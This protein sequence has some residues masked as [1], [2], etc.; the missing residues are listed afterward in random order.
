[1][2]YNGCKLQWDHE[3]VDVP[4]VTVEG[5]A[6]RYC[7]QNGLTVQ[8]EAREDGVKETYIVKD[9][10]ALDALALRLYGDF[11][12]AATKEN[13][14]TVA[15]S[16]TGERRF[17]IE[18]PEVW[19]ADG[20]PLRPDVHLENCITYSR[21]S[22]VFSKDELAR[23]AWPVTIDP[24]VRL[25]QRDGGLENTY[26][27][28]D[29]TT[30]YYGGSTRLVTGVYNTAESVSLFRLKTP[31][32][33]KASDT[34][35]SAKLMLTGSGSSYFSDNCVLGAYR[36]TKDWDSSNVTWSSFQPHASGS[37]DTKLLSFNTSNRNVQTW[38]ITD[39]YLSWYVKDEEGNVDNN[40]IALKRPPDITY[41]SYAEW[42]SS[43]SSTTSCRPCIVVDYLSHAGLEDWWQYETM[44]AGR[45]GTAH[46]DLLNG[47]LV[48]SHPDLA[49]GGLKLPFA[50]THYYNSCLSRNIAPHCGSGWRTSAHQT[51]RKDTI[52]GTDY[53]TWT[54]G[55]GTDH[56]FKATGS[57]PWEDAEG[58]KLRLSIDTSASTA[59][60][61]D[62]SHSQMVFPLPTGSGK[63]YIT[64][65]IDAKG[66]G[67]TNSSEHNC[68][69]T[70]TWDANAAGKL[71][72]A[73]DGAGR[74]T[75]FEYN[76]NDLLSKITA[77]DGRFVRYWYDGYRL[78]TVKYSDQADTPA[79]C[80]T[81]TYLSGSYLMTSMRNHDGT[82][83][84]IGYED[85]ATLESYANVGDH[86]DE[87]ARRV[88]RIELTNGDAK[89]A[90]KLF[91]Y[92]PSA[93]KVTEV[94]SNTEDTGK[95]LTY[96]FNESGNV[97]CVSDELGNA[98][99]AKFE[100]GIPNAVSDA[101]RM[102][103]AVINLLK[104][105]DFSANW[106]QASGTGSRDT[107]VRCLGMPSWQTTG[108]AAINQLI[109][110]TRSG[111]YT[112]SVYV[113]TTG[114]TGTGACCKLSVNGVTTASTLITESTAD[115]SN[116]PGAEGWERVFV[117]ADVPNGT[118]QIK[119]ILSCISTEGSV[120][121]AA[122]QLEA[123]GVPNRV[124]LLL[125]GDFAR[126][127]VNTENPDSDRLFPADWTKGAG[128]TTAIENCVRPNGHGMPDCLMGNALR[129]QSGKTAS[130][131]AFH[132]VVDVSGG[133][134]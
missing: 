132:Q 96:Q 45:A 59:T 90:K 107:G 29:Y 1:M 72:K 46:V 115:A 33:R 41:R 8:C 23:A 13:A 26:I 66:N 97:I 134:G 77:P 62:K 112:F 84:T 14:V 85:P 83:I 117:T 37:I 55:D 50:V 9:A 127:V 54:D 17:I 57:Q 79:K 32:Q 81:Y 75:L 21:M 128:I 114:L 44:T 49:T 129:M 93:T 123:G 94:R 131:V 12:I 105:M 86:Y 22:F 63:K 100:S 65:I 20:K 71:L 56:W 7:C 6:I 2:E 30:S 38:D 121:F 18:P 99:C 118:T 35:L 87:L 69:M 39:A 111:P 43:R 120:R 24:L 52:D 34:I 60:I 76:A 95:A 125:N 82:K 119:V 25:E 67:E 91:E 88:T 19:D 122:P 101:S 78:I 74:E 80:T 133:E 73:T 53:Y 103:K 27:R 40:G 116:G 36:I 16:R 98:Q 104:N 58:M 89:G 110:V 4:T 68:Q 42:Y 113:K 10:D 31:M 47:N 102:Q 5:A 11:D 61:T 108:S 106:T 126:T 51:L 48:V 15:D 92:L 3:G 124:N 130:D 109:P 64:K 70:F 28:S